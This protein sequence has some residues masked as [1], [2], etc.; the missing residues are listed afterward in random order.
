MSEMARDLGERLLAA[1]K[2][3]EQL[4]E[5]SPGNASSA[6]G[7]DVQALDNDE[8]VTTDEEDPPFGLDRRYWLDATKIIHVPE[9][10][11]AP[12]GTIEI[13][14]G[15]YYPAPDSPYTVMP[16]P[17]PAKYPLDVGDIVTTRPGQL[18]PAT[19]QELIPGVWVPDPNAGYQPSPPWAAPQQPIDVRD[20]MH[21][22]EGQLAPRGYVEYLPE[23][24]VREPSYYPTMIPPP[25]P[26]QR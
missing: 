21:I 6:G 13:G 26:P 3:V 15:L 10:E 14:P 17:P 22:P 9:G 4:Y 16:P 7:D 20:I 24:W 18:G 25:P 11:L 12:A 5:G 8:P 2:R 23:W 1:L 19:H